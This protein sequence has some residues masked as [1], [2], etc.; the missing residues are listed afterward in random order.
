MPNLPAFNRP[1]SKQIAAVLVAVILAVGIVA[2]ALILRSGRA[3][4]REVA[5]IQSGGSWVAGSSACLRPR[6]PN[7]NEAACLQSGGNWVP[8]L[9][10]G[11]DGTCIRG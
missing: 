7:P 6:A 9:A 11:Q 8:N 4:P 10:G 3:D 5:C 2:G 1:L